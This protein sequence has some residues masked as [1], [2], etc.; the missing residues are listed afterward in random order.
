[1]GR[2]VGDD[3]LD[4][5]AHRRPEPVIRLRIAV[6]HVAAGVVALEPQPGRGA[7]RWQRPHVDREAADPA[8]RVAGDPVRA[9]GA[10]RR[11]LRG[12][13]E[14]PAARVVAAVVEARNVRVV[15]DRILPARLELALDGAP[16]PGRVGRGWRSASRGSG[17]DRPDRAG[18]GRRGRGPV[19]RRGPEMR[20]GEAG[21]R[22]RPPRSSGSSRPLR[23]CRQAKRLRPTELGA[24]PAPRTVTDALRPVAS[25]SAKG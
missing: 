23:G 7:D 24:R 19:P 8:D 21:R 3:P 16:E 6:I 2:L 10:G 4:R 1:M 12:G 11:G 15:G 20:R 14:R 9:A 18:T 17:A 13:D 25:H 5:E 22:G